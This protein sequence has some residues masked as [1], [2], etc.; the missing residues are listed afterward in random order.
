M[1][2]SIRDLIF[3]ENRDG[4]LLVRPRHSTLDGEDAVDVANRRWLEQE[5]FETVEFKQGGFY[6]TWVVLTEENEESWLSIFNALS[7]LV[8]YPLLS[9]SICSEITTEMEAEC[10]D[11]YGRIDAK[12]LLSVQTRDELGVFDNENEILDNCYH[13]ALRE[14]SSYPFIQGESAI[15]P[16]DKKFAA[17]LEEKVKAAL[18]NLV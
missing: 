1:R 7:G 14:T 8:D 2:S 4:D 3:A 11:N 10:W 15:F 6:H 16:R 5:G 13:E 12:N 18:A 17:V 9:E